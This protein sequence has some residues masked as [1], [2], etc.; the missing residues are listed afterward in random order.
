MHVSGVQYA[1]KPGY[2]PGNPLG[3]LPEWLH[4]DDRAPHQQLDCQ[5]EWFALLRGVD[6]GQRNEAAARLAGR[7]LRNGFSVSE[8]RELLLLWNDRN[9]PPMNPH[10]VRRVASSIALRESRRLLT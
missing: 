8:T 5:L 7:F 1:W 2:E 9:R 10:E 4:T 3:P 6:E